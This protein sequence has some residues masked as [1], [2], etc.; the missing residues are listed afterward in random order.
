MV[1]GVAA[2]LEPDR[3]SHRAARAVAADDVPGAHRD[4]GCGIGAAQGDGDGAVALLPDRDVHHLEV[5]VGLEPARRAAHRAEE[6]V[7]NARLV[8]DH[9][10]ELG[11]AVLDVLHAA[12]ARDARPIAGV[13][14]PE[15]RLVYP[16]RLGDE[17]VAEPQRREHLHRAAGDAVGLAELERARP[18]LDDA[19][20]D[21]RELGE[22]RGEH[23]PGRPAADD[24]HVD[25]VRQGARPCRG[26]RIGG[27]HTRVA[28]SESVP[29]ELHDRGRLAERRVVER[30]PSRSL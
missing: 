11:Q 10:R 28:D 19:R 13:G 29:V 24:Q 22:L 14:S 6:V 16:I 17:R 12:G 9:V 2:E 20:R 4:L 15:H 1:G 27:P 25:L 3:L 7:V 30:Q 21:R 26:C 5:V 18:A 23:E 8:E